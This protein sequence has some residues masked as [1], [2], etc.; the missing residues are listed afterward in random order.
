MAQLGQS[1]VSKTRTAPEHTP[2]ES[3]IMNIPPAEDPLLY[4]LT[5]HLM[6]H[7][8]RARASRIVSN[9]LLHIHAWT[10]APPLPI[11]RQA[12]LDAAPAVRT[13]SHRTGGKTMFKP[14]ALSEKKRIFYALKHIKEASRAKPGLTIEERMAKEMVNIVQGVPSEAVKTKQKMHE[15]ATVN[16]RLLTQSN[17]S[18][19]DAHPLS[20]SAALSKLQQHLHQTYLS[21]SSPYTQSSLFA[22]YAPLTLL[23]SIFALPR[24]VDL[25]PSTSTSWQI[26]G[27]LLFGAGVGLV[28]LRVVIWVGARIVWA[29]CELD[30]GSG[31]EREKICGECRSADEEGEVKMEME[32]TQGNLILGGLFG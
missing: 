26:F 31:Q 15:F 32:L 2:A 27:Y 23:L 8:H 10:R 18:P 6:R 22:Q 7:G 1:A 17:M 13:L 9:I 16:R 3:T 28:L 21:P 11:L 5:S 29:F 24:F 30:L 14:T 12:I 19:I 4:Y 20:T 25:S